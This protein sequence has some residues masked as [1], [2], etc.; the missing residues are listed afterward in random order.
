MT[1]PPDETPDFLAKPASPSGE[2]GEPTLPMPSPYVAQPGYGTPPVPGQP[3]YSPYAAAP[4]VPGYP[5]ARSHTGANVAMGLGIT[6][7]VCALL[8]P[9]ICITIP[10]VLTGPFAIALGVRARK[11]MSQQPGAYNNSGAAM[12]GL[13]TGIIG[14]VLGLA[15]IGLVVFFVGFLF[16]VG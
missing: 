10:G 9:F 1:Q 7:V 5:L 14:T 4:G 15:M 8:T 13:V 3:P 11:E 12:A 16:S 6:S 2:Q